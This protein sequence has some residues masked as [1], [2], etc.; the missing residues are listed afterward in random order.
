MTNEIAALS[1]KIAFGIAQVAYREGLALEMPEEQL[2]AKI[3]ANYW[4]PTYRQY[5]R[6]SI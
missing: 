1:K 4:K 5:K 2:K 3:E 6:I